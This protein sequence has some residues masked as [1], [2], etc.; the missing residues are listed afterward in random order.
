MEA[1]T[2]YLVLRRGHM[3]TAD[4]SILIMSKENGNTFDPEKAASELVSLVENSLERN[5]KKSFPPNRDQIILLIS[6][7]Y[8]GTVDSTNW[9]YEVM[10]WAGWTP[11][12]Y[13][14]ENINLCHIQF[15][16]AEQWLFN[17][18]EKENPNWKAKRS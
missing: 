15:E 6:E 17:C 16:D 9:H 4:T 5:E 13:F 1:S 11:F 12:S 2:K 10:D 7:A 18:W 8:W 3:E 14:P